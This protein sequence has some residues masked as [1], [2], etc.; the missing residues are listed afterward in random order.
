MDIAITMICL[1][2]GLFLVIIVAIVGKQDSNLC[3]AVATFV[4]PSR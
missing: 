3:A 1:Y 2:K 4:E